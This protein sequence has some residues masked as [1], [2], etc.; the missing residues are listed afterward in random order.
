MRRGRGQLRPFGGA[1]NGTA[2]LRMQ[3][4]RVR[5]PSATQT[6][7]TNLGYL[8]CSETYGSGRARFIR[9]I[10]T[11]RKTAARIKTRVP[12]ALCVEDRGASNRSIFALLPGSR[13]SHTSL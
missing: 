6:T 3:V 13:R 9:A 7:E 8:T 12:P 2:S 10:R 11:R 1:T 5:I 4:G